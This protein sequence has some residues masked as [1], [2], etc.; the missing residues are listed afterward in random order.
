MKIKNNAKFK[1]KNDVNKSISGKKETFNVGGL[2][3]SSCANTVQRTLSRLEGVKSADVNFSAS[4]ATV[5]YDPTVVG[6]GQ[7][8]DATDDGQR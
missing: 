8:V 6:P 7:M 2:S 3:C 5:E 4:S 1:I